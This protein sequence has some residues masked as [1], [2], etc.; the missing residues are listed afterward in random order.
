MEVAFSNQYTAEASGVQVV[1]FKTNTDNMF[2]ESPQL[3]DVGCSKRR[4][5]Q[6]LMPLDDAL[7]KQHHQHLNKSK[8]DNLSNCES[9]S[10]LSTDDSERGKALT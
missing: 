10:D 4:H 1:S 3:S 9:L 5:H 7:T 6:Q 2:P 8:S